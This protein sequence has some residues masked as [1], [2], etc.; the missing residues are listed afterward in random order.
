MTAR[1][2]LKVKLWR[3]DDLS[4]R[5]RVAGAAVPGLVAVGCERACLTGMAPLKC[6]EA[7]RDRVNGLVR[8]ET[9]A[10][11]LPRAE[12]VRAA[13]GTFVAPPAR[14]DP[15]ADQVDDWLQLAKD[16]HQGISEQLL[17]KEIVD[18]LRRRGM[19]K[20]RHPEFVVWVRECEARGE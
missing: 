1:P 14:S 15:D 20:N 2:E 7:L 6:P 3:V 11:H 9:L 12:V 10:V 4:L 17:A 8:G 18:L 5:M 13:G 19:I 16:I